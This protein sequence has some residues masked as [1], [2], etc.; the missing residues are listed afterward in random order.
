M[1]RIADWA[2]IPAKTRAPGYAIVHKPIPWI[3]PAE[4]VLQRHHRPGRP[5][6]RAHARGRTRTGLRPRLDHLP[7]H[8]AQRGRNPPQ[9][10]PHRRHRRHPQS[11]HGDPRSRRGGENQAARRR[12]G[13]RFRRAHRR[14]MPRVR[15]A[16]REGESFRR[17]NRGSR[18]ALPERRRLS[19]AEDPPRRILR[20]A[21]GARHRIARRHRRRETRRARPGERTARPLRPDR[22]NNS[23]RSTSAPT[24]NRASSAR[25]TPPR[26]SRRWSAPAPCRCTAGFT[27]W[28]FP[29]SASRPPT[30]SR[31]STKPSK[32]SPAR[33]CCATCWNCSACARKSAKRKQTP[34]ARNSSPPVSRNPR[35]RKTP[36]RATPWSW[37]APSPRRRCST[38]SRAPAGRDG[39]GALGETRHLARAARRKPPPQPRHPFAGKTFVLTGTLPTLSRDEASALIREAGGNVTGSVSK[40]TDYVLAGESAG[41]KLD[42]ARELGVEILTEE[43]ILGDAR[44][45]PACK[46]PNARQPAVEHLAPTLLTP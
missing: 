6:R 28:R 46:A 13:V 43:P 29:K 2:R 35:R 7:R 25:R 27:R 15:R 33:S 44:H 14:Q 22:K 1:N 19:R 24:T 39:S 21:Q 42:K 34:P 10:H 26:S 3:T 5:H 20:P 4:T 41:S 32:T 8:A 17:R 31:S 18:L 9:R 16:D 23:P 45:H 30:T 11:R 36:P 40:N 12:E 37:S 38:G